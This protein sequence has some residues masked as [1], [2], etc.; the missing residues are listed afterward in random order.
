MIGLARDRAEKRRKRRER[1]TV[2]GGG[3]DRNERGEGGVAHYALLA[4]L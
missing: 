3:D 4:D 2:E 1:E